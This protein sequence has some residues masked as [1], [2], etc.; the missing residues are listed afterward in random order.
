MTRIALYPGSFDPVTNGHMDILRQ[1]LALADKVVVA[2]GIHPGKTPLF[3]FEERVDLI[4]ASAAS[5]FS[6]DEAKRVEII[7]FSGLVVNA[8][9]EHGATI[10]VRGLRDGTDLD[11]EMQMAGMNQTMAPDIQTVFLPASPTVRHI[12][13]TLVRQISKMGGEIKDFV[14]DPVAEPVRQRAKPG[15]V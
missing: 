3:S 6:A 8:A 4:K 1:S 14:P 2:I 15:Q 11:Y 12:T 9:R 13:A 5:E 7:A 10:L